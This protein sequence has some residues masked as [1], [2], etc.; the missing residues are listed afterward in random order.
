[1]TNRWR[2]TFRIVVALALAISLGACGDD[3]ASSSNTNG[4]N[5]NGNSN[6][7]QTV[8]PAGGQV[9]GPDGVTVDIPTGALDAEVEIEIIIAS[10]QPSGFHAVGTVYEFRPTGLQ[11]NSPV[12]VTLPYTASDVQQLEDG[13]QIWWSS[14]VDGTYEA[15][16]STVDTAADKVSAQVTHF[17]FGVAGEPAQAA[18]CG[19]GTCAQTESCAT[20]SQDCCTCTA[21]SAGGTAQGFAINNIVV[22]TSAADATSIGID[23]DGD[24]AIDNKLGKVCGLLADQ[25]GDTSI[26]E[27]VELDLAAGDLVMLGQ[28][29]T[30]SWDNDSQVFAQLLTG[31]YTGG[32]PAFDGNDQATVDTDT[33]NDSG[34]CGEVVASSLHT[35]GG[36]FYAQ[37]PICALTGSLLLYVEVSLEAAGMSGVVQA[38][39]WT[40]VMVGGAVSLADRD[41]VIYPAYQAE[42]AAAIAADPS[43][44]TSQT[45]L[46]LLDNSCDLTVCDPIP[47]ECADDGAITVEEIRCNGLINAMYAPDLDL[48]NDGTNDHLSVG[49]QVA[50]VPATLTP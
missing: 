13:L 3:D 33:P 37:V 40:D 4:N 20:C 22:P 34:A 6:Q 39:G 24:G 30:D 44:A 32:T 31:S 1:M 43:S 25:S 12:T 18:V 2:I 23:V 5:T 21:T 14:T 36:S 47:T 45:L 19:D 26:F 38:G 11:F 42:V 15:L 7:G 50:A 35:H 16:T 9:E 49:F 28:M 41:A 8:G 46:N 27:Q 48:D 17:S 10:G 29:W